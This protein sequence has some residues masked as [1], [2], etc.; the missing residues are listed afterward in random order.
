MEFHLTRKFN[1]VNHF[2]GGILANCILRNFISST[3]EQKRLVQYKILLEFLRQK[4]KDWLLKVLFCVS[5][6]KIHGFS[7]F[8]GC[9]QHVVEVFRDCFYIDWNIILN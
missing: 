4:K 5:A 2:D 8:F 9:T 1:F 3:S 7:F 6:C